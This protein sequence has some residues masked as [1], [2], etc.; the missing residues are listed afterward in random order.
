MK[1]LLEE[2]ID[3]LKKNNKTEEDVVFCITTGGVE[4]DDDCEEEC[5]ASRFSFQI[6]KRLANFYY[7]NGFGGVRVDFGLKIVGDS[8][9]L[10]RAQYDGSEWWEF[11]TMPTPPELELEWRGRAE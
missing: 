6:F 2:T 8:W 4:L 5:P 7:D 3:A 11:K 10:E 1:T 9:W